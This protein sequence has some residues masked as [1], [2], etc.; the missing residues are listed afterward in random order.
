MIGDIPQWSDDYQY[1]LAAHMRNVQAC[2]TTAKEAA[3]YNL[4]AEKRAAAAA[5]V[6]Y[7]SP[8]PWVCARQCEPIIDGM[9]VFN[10][11]YDLTGTYVQYLSEALQ[12]A[13]GLP[14]VKS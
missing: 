14:D 7:I 8:G 6:Q 5:K 1:C 12:Q 9:R 11:Q 13:L 4:A 2:A 3:P 10:D